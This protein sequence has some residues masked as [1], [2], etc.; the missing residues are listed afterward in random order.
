[1]VCPIVSSVADTSLLPCSTQV[2]TLTHQT[3]SGAALVDQQL[4][5]VMGGLG[6]TTIMSEG[7]T[8]K[9]F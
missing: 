1:L 2:E 7:V 8:E 6:S 3:W 5:T 9:Q 4:Q